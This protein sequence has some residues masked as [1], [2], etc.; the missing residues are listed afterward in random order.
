M[1]RLTYIVMLGTSALTTTP[2]GICARLAARRLHWGDCMRITYEF[3]MVKC[4]E[5]S[6][7]M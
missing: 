7:G 5:G 4:K 3:A 1:L 2:E 6:W